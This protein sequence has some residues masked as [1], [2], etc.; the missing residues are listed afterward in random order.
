MKPSCR[1]EKALR[2]DHHIK[3]EFGEAFSL[4]KF[5]MTININPHLI[6]TIK[7]KKKHYKLVSLKE[8]CE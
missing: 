8:Q 3:E 7:K 2:M 5:F 1:W 4:N 6:P